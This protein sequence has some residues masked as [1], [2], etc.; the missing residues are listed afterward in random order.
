MS[1][2]FPPEV[3]ECPEPDECPV[4]IDALSGL[5]TNGRLPVATVATGQ[6]WSR[7][8]HSRYG[9]MEF[10]PGYGNARFSPFD[11]ALDGARI[12]SICLAASPEAALLE[13]A[14]RDIDYENEPEVQEEDFH[15]YLHVE[16]LS[17]ESFRVADL[18]DEQLGVLRLERT[19]VSSNLSQHYPCTRTIAKAVHASTQDLSGILWH[20]RQAELSRQPQ[21]EVLVLFEERTAGG[22]KSFE[23]NPGR[24]SIGA[25]Y[26][27]AGRVTLDELL[28]ELGVNVAGPWG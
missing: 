5:A 4:A 11:S 8:Y 10:N 26:E 16:L 9:H 1:E 14:L 18:R 27:G 3:L 12:A 15:G 25:L 22:R 7:V 24:K 23:L 17:S 19:A 28:E 20:S 21:E 6:P 13:T 2:E